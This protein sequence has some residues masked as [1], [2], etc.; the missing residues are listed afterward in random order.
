MHTFL[1]FNDWTFFSSWHLVQLRDF[2]VIFKFNADLYLNLYVQGFVRDS[3]TKDRSHLFSSSW[4][5]DTGSLHTECKRQ[6][7]LKFVGLSHLDSQPT[8]TAAFWNRWSF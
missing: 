4:K 1:N 7:G 5:I 8:N 6:A 3:I 2:V